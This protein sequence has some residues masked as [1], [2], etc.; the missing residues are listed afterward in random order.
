LAV[1]PH[2]RPSVASWYLG[3]FRRRGRTPHRRTKRACPQRLRHPLPPLPQLRAQPPSSRSTA[4]FF[5]CFRSGGGADVSSFVDIAGGLARPTSR[6]GHPSAEVGPAGIQAD[7][8]SGGGGCGDGLP[9]AGTKPTWEVKLHTG[10]KV[11]SNISSF[12]SYV[13]ENGNFW[14]SN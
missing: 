9:I 5:P 4:Y 10:K 8:D 3:G 1:H 7:C 11:T 2:D 13:H 6:S 14:Y 12:I